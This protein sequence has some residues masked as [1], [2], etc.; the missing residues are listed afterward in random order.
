M[1]A[2]CLSVCT[3]AVT[4]VTFYVGD[5]HAGDREPY[6]AVRTGLK[7]SQCHVNRTGGGGRTDFGSAWAQTV[8]PMRT[9]GIRNRA[10]NE[11]ISV[12]ADVRYLAR[13]T[14]TEAT[15]RT[16]LGLNEAQLQLEG[17]FIP[18]RLSLY[19]DEKLGP[20]GA[21]A[22]ELFALVKGLPLNGY[23]KAGKFI[24]PFGWRL[25]DDDA[26]IR[27]QTG[28]TFKTPDQGVEFGIEPGHL[29]FAV[30]LSN[31]NQGAV[32]SNS[33]K[34]VT[35][36]ASLVY[37]RFRIGGSASYNSTS[38]SQRGIFGGFTGF[39]IGPLTV[40]GEADYITDSFDAAADVNQF[41]GY[42]EGNYLATKGVNAKVTYG[43]HDPDTD[44]SEN[45][46]IRM[47][48]GLETFPVTFVQLSAFYTLLDD[49]PQVTTDVDVVSVELHV[50]F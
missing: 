33:E 10:L 37:R 12:G 34:Q 20:D 7:C 36:R 22:R 2:R 16:D 23:A 3:L 19:I 21:D 38:N 27:A 15:P 29:A 32:E 40:L 30:A 47:R 4:I 35:S 1:N 31:G 44:V 28:F 8:L 11:W 45:Q 26:F 41:V 39:S 5:L 42:V 14:V 24:L 46:R 9:V 50:H 48:F 18:N 49:I 6:L 13:G 43:F 17:N 25:W